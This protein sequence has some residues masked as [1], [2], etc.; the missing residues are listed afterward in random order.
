MDILVLRFYPQA[1]RRQARGF[2]ATTFACLSTTCYHY[3]TFLVEYQF[4]CLQKSNPRL[5]PTS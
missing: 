2:L 5:N 4:I 1:N 3:T